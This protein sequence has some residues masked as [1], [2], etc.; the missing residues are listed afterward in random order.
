MVFQMLDEGWDDSTICNKLGMEPEE[1]VK[2]KHVTGFSKLF[3]NS[4]YSRAWVAR[5]QIRLSKK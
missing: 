2:L 4:E 5:N 3:E 1:L